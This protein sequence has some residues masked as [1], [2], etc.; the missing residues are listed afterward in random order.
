MKSITKA[1]RVNS[2]IQVIQHMNSGMTVVDACEEI[3]LPRSSFYDIVKKNPE[4]IAE[5][6]EMVRI[7][8]RQQ[9]GLILL[10][11]TEILNKIIQ[12][13]LSDDTSPRERLAIYKQLDELDSKL[14]SSIQVES[15]AA[16]HI[17]EML[18]AGPKTKHIKSRVTATQTT[19]TVEKED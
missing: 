2:A 3:G 14:H 7:N 19:V 13:A 15:E 9:L 17:H 10:H 12:D 18:K 5:Y 6:Q 8:A 11:K 16:A 4:A 1:S